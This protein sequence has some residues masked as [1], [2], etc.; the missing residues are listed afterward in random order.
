MC[1]MSA[2]EVLQ[3]GCTARGAPADNAAAIIS[4]NCPTIWQQGGFLKFILQFFTLQ[5]EFEAMML[6]KKGTGRTANTIN[7]H[8]HEIPYKPLADPAKVPT[9]VSWARTGADG[10]VKDQASCGSCEC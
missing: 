8:S 5:E 2:E 3:G 4:S 7:K 1:P 6:P 10:T 9:S